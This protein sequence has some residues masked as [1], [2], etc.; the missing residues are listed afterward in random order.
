M[1]RIL[2]AILFLVGLFLLLNSI[3]FGIR[4]A[5]GIRLAHESTAFQL[6]NADALRR[7]LVVGDST[8]V[9]TGA[10]SPWDSVAGRIAR[11]FPWVEI[12]N[13][14]EDGAKI[15]DVILQMDALEDTDFDL[16]LVQAG[17]NDILRFTGL[18]SLER[19]VAELLSMAASRGNHVIFI[20]TGNVGTAPAFFPPVNWIYTCRTRQARSLFL[21]VSRQLHV[22][23]V[24]LF[25]EKRDDPFLEDPDKTFARDFLH[26]GSSGYG[27]WYEEL[28]RQTSLKE[29]LTPEGQ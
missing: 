8:G 23:Y 13:T 12:I 26:P 21:R 17:G 3:V 27:L 15:A 18:A 24:D 16:V 5:Q 2:W 19:D 9:G 28:R 25:K 7:V 20:S 22:E 10:E 6:W 29:I 11:D 4:V 14:S 1:R